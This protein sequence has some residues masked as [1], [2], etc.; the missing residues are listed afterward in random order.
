MSRR[1]RTRPKSEPVNVTWSLANGKGKPKPCPDPLPTLAMHPEVAKF[2][3][4]LLVADLPDSG[5]RETG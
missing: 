2:L 1:K 3:A 5:K 4:D